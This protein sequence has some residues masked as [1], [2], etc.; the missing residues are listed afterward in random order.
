MGR[1]DAKKKAKQ[2]VREQL[3]RERRRRRVVW[4]SLFGVLLLV[5]SGMI[6]YGIYAGQRPPST[7]TPPPD[8]TQTTLG[9][10][11]GNGPVTVEVYHDFL[12]PGCRQFEEIAGA[13]IDRLIATNQ[14]TVVFHPV[15][16]LNRYSTTAYSTRSAA[17]SGCAAEA[18]RF[19]DYAAALYRRQPAEGGP[20]LSN[21]E[22]ASIGVELGFGDE[23]RRCV[24][25]GKYRPWVERLTDEAAR[26]GVVA[27]PTVFVDG[28]PVEELSPQAITA[29]VEAA[30][31]R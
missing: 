6:G 24:T 13:A 17:A 15:A 14:A 9:I 30:R 29:A 19:R 16:F 26:R 28:K 1:K 23:F 18:G 20:G 31:D 21:S 2:V 25:S 11:V 12:C 7:Y 8:A 4:T 5:I 10:P 27:T 3:A 22:L